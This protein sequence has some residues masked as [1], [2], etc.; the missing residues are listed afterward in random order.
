MLT[1]KVL[2]PFQDVCGDI[3]LERAS[4]PGL[5]LSESGS[6][7]FLQRA[8]KTEDRVELLVRVLWQA[9]TPQ[10]FGLKEGTVSAPPI[11]EFSRVNKLM[12]T[13]PTLPSET[14]PCF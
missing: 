11:H 3:L 13:G 10:P 8:R 9:G 4:P 5:A 12:T 14:A 6:G 1:G 7:S 2:G